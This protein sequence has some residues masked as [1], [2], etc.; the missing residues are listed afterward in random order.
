[1]NFVP[2]PFTC[3]SIIKREFMNAGRLHPPKADNPPRKEV[4]C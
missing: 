4:K 2:K 3:N 1:M